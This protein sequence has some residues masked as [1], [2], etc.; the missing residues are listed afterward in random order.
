MAN[1]VGFKKLFK[2]AMSFENFFMTYPLSNLRAVKQTGHE[3]MYGAH[4]L[5]AYNKSATKQIIVF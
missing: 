2:P 5:F 3:N 4:Y 1:F